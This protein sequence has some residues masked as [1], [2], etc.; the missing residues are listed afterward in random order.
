[1]RWS[2]SVWKQ[3][4]NYNQKEII[5]EKQSYKKA[6]T[7]QKK[8]TIKPNKKLYLILSSQHY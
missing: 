4:Q 6:L 8:K 3:S 2:T 5:E 1:M 7:Q